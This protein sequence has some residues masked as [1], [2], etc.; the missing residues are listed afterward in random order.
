LL[1]EQKSQQKRQKS[2]VAVNGLCRRILS[3][4]EA[5]GDLHFFSDSNIRGLKAGLVTDRLRG[6]GFRRLSRY[7]IE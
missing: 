2:P 4:E 6:E 3:H 1:P 5:E 7:L